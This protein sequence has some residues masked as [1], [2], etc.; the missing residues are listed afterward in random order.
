MIAPMFGT[1]SCVP[2]GQLVS[3]SRCPEV[4]AAVF[5]HPHGRYMPNAS[6]RRVR[7]PLEIGLAG[8]DA[9]AR[10]MSAVSCLTRIAST[11]LRKGNGARVAKLLNDAG[12]ADAVRTYKIRF[13]EN[14]KA[15]RLSLHLTQQALGEISGHG[16]VYVQRIESGQIN[17]SLGTMISLA[18]AIGRP[19]ED[20]FRAL[21]GDGGTVLK[22][23]AVG[24]GAALRENVLAIELPA[25]QAFE[26]GLFLARHLGKPIP[27]IDPETRTISGIAGVSVGK[28]EPD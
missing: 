23:N 12:E 4:L 21:H 7:T 26:A 17:V 11:G 9:F 13:G 3:S 5:S 24:S 28:R 18:R 8:A 15:V 20:L 10:R 14:L 22:A 16:R 25:G 27:L 1:V 2:E 19:V 6:V